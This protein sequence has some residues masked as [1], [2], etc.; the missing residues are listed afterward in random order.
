MT[1][2]YKYQAQGCFSSTSKTGK[3]DLMTNVAL[4]GWLVINYFWQFFLCAFIS[5]HRLTAAAWNCV[6]AMHLAPAHKVMISGLLNLACFMTFIPWCLVLL[7]QPPQR[8]KQPSQSSWKKWQV[9]SGTMLD[10][11]WGQSTKVI[12]TGKRHTLIS[13]SG[14]LL[15]SY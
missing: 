11:C 9:P 2:T 13:W 5:R 3:N 8:K 15:L 1:S 4:I 10:T 7:P 12:T 6:W 14:D